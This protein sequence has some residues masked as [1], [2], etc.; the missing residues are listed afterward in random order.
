MS[1]GEKKLV[2]KLSHQ[3]N[4]PLAAIRNALFLAGAHSGSNTI[5]SYLKLADQQ[6]SRIA[7]ILRQY[8][9]DQATSTPL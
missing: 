5:A 8:A 4:S 6:V 1:S 9:D 3:I 2:A 7:G